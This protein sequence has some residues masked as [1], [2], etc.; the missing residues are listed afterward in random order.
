VD[1]VLIPVW[2]DPGEV[3][4]SVNIPLE[5]FPL[6]A[7]L[8]AGFLLGLA[9][10]W[11]LGIIQAKTARELAE[12]L[13][14]ESEGK[15]REQLEMI[16]DHLKDAFGS[17]SMEALS[18]STEEFLKLARSRMETERELGSRELEEKKGLI[19][20]QLEA[21]AARMESLSQLV[22]ELEKDR[23]EKFGE[24]AGKLQ[25]VSRSATQLNETTDMLRRALANTK[26]RGQWGERMAE[27]VLR[28]AGFA[29]GINYQRQM[30]LED[31]SRPDF[32]FMLPK[33]LL[34]NMDVKFPYDNYLRYLEAEGR[35]GK[36]S[37]CKA[38]LRDVRA[39]VREVSTRSYIDPKKGTVDCALLFIPNEQV[40]AF[41]HEQDP[42]LFDEALA[43]KVVLCS[44][45]TLYAVLAVI[46]Q[47]VDNFALEET[48]RE[49]LSLYGVFRKQWEAFI[50][51]LDL[52]GKRLFEAQKE[53]DALV[54]TRRRNLDKSLEQIENLRTGEGVQTAEEEKLSG[55]EV[56][57]EEQRA[58]ETS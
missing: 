1:I 53:Y 27:D 11:L 39:R 34:L 56:P 44:P 42:S 13:F 45:V 30:T 19:D 23:V 41:I 10:A 51:K 52:L 21:M 2:K 5:F 9:A 40:Y 14:E 26:A 12:E 57:K 25:E 17:L 18:R 54:T 38:F 43:E 46:R 24:L 16:T 15:K 8:V 48:S 35:E 28:A 37:S 6:V 22:K 58:E 20:R 47:A 31:G 55:G 36:E 3:A 7:A 32:T 29:E 49:I 4:T 50:K 33:G